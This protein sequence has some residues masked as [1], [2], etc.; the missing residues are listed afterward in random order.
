[1]V[2]SIKVSFGKK[3]FKSFIDYEHKDAKK[4]H[5]YAYSFEIWVNTEEI[6]IKLKLS[7][8]W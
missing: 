8:F 6:L 1:M 3:N 4:I 7:L 5:L 2:V